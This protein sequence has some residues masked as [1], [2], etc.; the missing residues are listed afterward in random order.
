MEKMA[1]SGQRWQTKMATKNGNKRPKKKPKMAI[2]PIC[3]LFFAD[4]V[5]PP[6]VGDKH[7]PF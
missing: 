2:S 4:F 5:P 7:W 1:K 6:P 3:G